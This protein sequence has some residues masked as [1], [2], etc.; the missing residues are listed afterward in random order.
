MNNN[1]LKQ[2]FK[3]IGDIDKRKEISDKEYKNN[4]DKKLDEIY[5]YPISVIYKLLDEIYN[6]LDNITA[7][8][9]R[10]DENKSELIVGI[11]NTCSIIL[12]DRPNNITFTSLC[13]LEYMMS[14]TYANSIKIIQN[15][16]INKSQITC[17]DGSKN[18]Y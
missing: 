15:E 18:I 9:E 2:D 8:E 1:I 7:S 16:L 5:E 6:N 17:I 12:E 3:N 13:D 4:H 14:K 10:F 11:L